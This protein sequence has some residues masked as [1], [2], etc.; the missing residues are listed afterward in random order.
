MNDYLLKCINTGMPVVFDYDG[1]LFEARWY[2]KR[3]NM[4]N[5]TEEKLIEAHKKG[6]NLYTKPIPSVM[7]FVAGLRNEVFV[8]SHMHTCIEYQV[9]CKQLELYY[10]KV[11]QNHIYAALCI[12][13]KIRYLKDIQKRYHSFIY[14]DDSY[15]TL[16]KFENYFE[17]TCKFFH[18]SSLYV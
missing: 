9:K 12:D 13:D 3:I 14:I 11:K 2:K 1:V 10:P 8:L 18:V 6:K 5:E 7:E 4:V 15:S 16:I 17:D